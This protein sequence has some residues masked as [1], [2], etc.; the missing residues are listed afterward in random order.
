M[1][2]CLAFRVVRAVS[3]GGP[4]PTDGGAVPEPSTVLFPGH[5][6]VRPGHAAANRLSRGVR[7]KSP[8]ASPWYRAFQMSFFP[9]LLCAGLGAVYTG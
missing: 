7:R 9:A 6:F 1:N 2:G 3:I 5:R 8:R 4:S